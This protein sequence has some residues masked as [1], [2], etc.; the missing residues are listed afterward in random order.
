[1]TSTTLAPPN[2]RSARCVTCD[3]TFTYEYRGGQVRTWCTPAHKRA[4]KAESQRRYVDRQSGS[5]DPLAD[6]SSAVPWP[7]PKG[8]LTEFRETH[9]RHREAQARRVDRGTGGT[10]PGAYL[11][12]IGDD[13][14]PDDPEPDIDGVLGEVVRATHPALV[15]TVSGHGY[16]M[17]DHMDVD[18]GPLLAYAP[19]DRD[20]V[21]AEFKRLREPIA[22]L[23]VGRTA[24]TPLR[25]LGSVD[26]PYGWDQG[27]ATYSRGCS[28]SRLEP[29]APFVKTV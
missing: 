11:G 23:T 13:D 28:V 24:S 7:L 6:Y 16:V 9:K 18:T 10:D 22:G 26:R 29:L 27:T 8:E 19:R 15:F 2:L 12:D 17:D 25:I 1:M 4:R 20:T 14:P 5:E 3:E 21:R